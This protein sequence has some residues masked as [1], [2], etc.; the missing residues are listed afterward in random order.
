MPNDVE[1]KW[2]VH[3]KGAARDWVTDER[4]T[5]V[6]MVVSGVGRIQF[7][8]RDAVLNKPGD[9]VM[10]GPG[11]DHRRI[12]DQDCTTVTVRWFSSA[13]KANRGGKP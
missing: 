11:T 3:K 9:Y 8:D 5:T 12:A 1:I 7:R 6:C 4:R 10:W 13:A 2:A